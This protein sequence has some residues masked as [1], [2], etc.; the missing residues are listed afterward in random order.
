VGPEIYVYSGNPIVRYSDVQ[1]GWPGTGNIDADPVFVGPYNEDFHL[2]WRSPCIDAGDPASPLDPDGTRNDIGAFYFNQDVDGIV[3]LYPHD[4]PIVIPPE[5]GDIVYDGWVFNFSNNPLTIDIRSYLYLDGVGR[6]HRVHKHKDVSIAVGDS[7][8]ENSII[9]TVPGFSPAGDYTL[10]AY[11]GDFP[12][13]E[14]I[15]SCYFYFTKTG[16]VGD[17]I[18]GCFEAD[19]WLKESHL[20]GS[21]LANVYALSQNYPNP[22]NALTVIK[23]QLP[24]NGHLKLEIYNLLGQKVATLVDGE[25]QAGYRSVVWDAS[26]VS[27]GLYFYKLTAG[28]YTETRRMMLVK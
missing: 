7:I 26:E 9:K 10:V 12:T 22:F 15:D 4:T 19:E 24:V 13:R 28:D 21:N 3:E 1:G 17:G 18:A 5:G 16:P 11:I 2:R 23:Y 8:G 6:Y 27:S 20:A 25:Q 14:I